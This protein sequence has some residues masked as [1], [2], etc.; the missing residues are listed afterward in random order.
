[1]AERILRPATA[2]SLA[3]SSSKKKRP[4]EHNED[5]LKF[6]RQLPCLISGLRGCDAAHIRYPDPRFAKLHTA[7]GQKPH[8]KWTVPLHRSIHMDQHE[9]NEREWWESKGLDPVVIAAALYACSGDVEAGEMIV[10]Q[11]R[12]KLTARRKNNGD[13]SSS[14]SGNSPQ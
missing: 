8:D 1:M 13:R 7:M 11:W 9:H 4:R 2:F 6:I 3:G 14:L 12:E 10:N 5:H